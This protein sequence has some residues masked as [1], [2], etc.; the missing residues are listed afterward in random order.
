[1]TISEFKKNY[2]KVSSPS[3]IAFV[4]YWGKY[5]D[6]LPINP[7]ISMTLKNC[8]SIFEIEFIPRQNSLI[9]SFEFEGAKNLKFQNRME[10]FLKKVQREFSFFSKFSISI[11]CHNT[12]PHSSGIASSASAMSALVFALVSYESFTFK[13]V[14]DLK[15]AS[16]VSRLASGSASRSLYPHIVQWGKNFLKGSSDEYAIA[17]SDIHDS[18]LTLQDSVLIIDNKEKNFSSSFGHSLMD[19]HFFKESRVKQANSNMSDILDS[20][21]VGD[22]S[23]FGKILENEA[24]TLHGLMM[25]SDPSVILLKPNSLLAIERVRGFREKTGHHLYFTID[26]G[27]N[28]HLLYPE[29]SKQEVVRFIENELK[30]LCVNQRVIHDQIGT[31]PEVLESSFDD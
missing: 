17:V 2:I 26:A 11:Q 5:G 28:I 23:V 31:G 24:L 25:T 18:F 12:F 13:S 8:V 7:S 4:K 29:S 15:K 21:R 19:T 22:F 1:M 30:S 27:A 9:H 14:A 16:R 20:L 3:N 10:K 6:Q